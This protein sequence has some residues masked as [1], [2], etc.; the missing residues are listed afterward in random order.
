M[1]VLDPRELIRMAVKDEETGIAFYKALSEVV[2]QPGLK[3]KMLDIVEQE[4]YHAERFRKFLDEIG[5]YEPY[6]QYP[7]EYENYVQT[8]LESKAF[9]TPEAAAQQARR[10]GLGIE[11]IDVALGLEKDTL[12]FL[13]EMRNFVKEDMHQY[14][15]AI[16]QEERDHV[17]ELSVL[18]RELKK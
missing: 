5:D 11:A 3:K 18:R 14:L 2:R 6:E 1:Q 9:P 13:T 4:K 17:V 10:I 16:I 7:G 12:L 15:D 8:L